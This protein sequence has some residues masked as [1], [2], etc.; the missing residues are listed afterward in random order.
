MGLDVQNTN[1]LMGF[2]TINYPT[3][4]AQQFS[5]TQITSL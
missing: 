5:F 1:Q 3:Q 2:W 4:L